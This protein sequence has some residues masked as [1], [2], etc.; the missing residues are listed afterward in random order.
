MSQLKVDLNIYMLPLC[1]RKICGVSGIWQLEI[2]SYF[3]QILYY[4]IVDDSNT[5]IRK[6]RNAH[7]NK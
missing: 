2:V 1:Q 7:Q 5:I 6:N 4:R 3:I